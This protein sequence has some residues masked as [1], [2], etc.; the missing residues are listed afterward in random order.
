MTLATYDHFSHIPEDRPTQLGAD[1]VSTSDLYQMYQ[2][3]NM[4]SP[5]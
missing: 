2:A 4:Y 5:L 3:T 1:L